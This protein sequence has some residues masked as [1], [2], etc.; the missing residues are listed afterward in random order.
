VF[1]LAQA[2]LAAAGWIPAGPGSPKAL[3]PLAASRRLKR[4]NAI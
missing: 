3:F 4:I 2:V 1:S